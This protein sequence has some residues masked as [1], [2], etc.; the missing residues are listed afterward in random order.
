MIEVRVDEIE[1]CDVALEVKLLD[2]VLP[3]GPDVLDVA[4]VVLGREGRVADVLEHDPRVRRDVLDPLLQLEQRLQELVRVEDG[5][6]LV[7]LPA[8]VHV[9]E[10]QKGVLG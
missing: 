10:L 6:H 1:L 2:V 7:G 8:H 4:H 3:V 9:L 5:A